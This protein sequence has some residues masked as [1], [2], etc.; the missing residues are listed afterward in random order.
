M[1]GPNPYERP[2]ICWREDFVP[3]APLFSATGWMLATDDPATGSCARTSPTSPS[4][5]VTTDRR[6]PIWYL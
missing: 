4:L 2:R 6:R 3:P 1:E 5:D